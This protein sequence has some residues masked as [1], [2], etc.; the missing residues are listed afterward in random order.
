L[1]HNDFFFFRAICFDRRRRQMYLGITEWAENH[2]QNILYARKLISV[3]R[4][5]FFFLLN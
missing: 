3:K 5:L 2:S 4:Y 1:S